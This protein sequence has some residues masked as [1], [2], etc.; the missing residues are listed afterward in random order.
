MKSI[1]EKLYFILEELETFKSIVKK[2]K[3][4]IQIKDFK[5][6]ILKKYKP[7]N[8][9]REKILKKARKKAHNT[10][11]NVQR[12]MSNNLKDTDIK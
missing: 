6:D 3:P 8:Y 11:A 1:K 4:Q 7:K 9:T 5:K 2:S 12:T 10:L